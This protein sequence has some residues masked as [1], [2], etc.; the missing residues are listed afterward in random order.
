MGCELV[1]VHANDDIDQSHRL[2]ECTVT[3]RNP[4]FTGQDRFSVGVLLF[5]HCNHT[6]TLARMNIQRAHT[7]SNIAC[8]MAPSEFTRLHVL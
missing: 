8:F 7:S 4:P 6:L 2:S 3:M 1:L 5:C